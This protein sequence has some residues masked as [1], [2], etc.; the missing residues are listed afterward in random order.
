MRVDGW[1]EAV[2]GVAHDYMSKAV[3][4]FSDIAMMLDD[5]RQVSSNS[6]G[7]FVVP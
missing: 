6:T 5:F 2:I 4:N 7:Q 3:D 1:R